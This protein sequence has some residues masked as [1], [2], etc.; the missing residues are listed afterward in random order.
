MP[1]WRRLAEDGAAP[2]LW[3]AGLVLIVLGNP[4][5]GLAL[6]A[7][8]VVARA[9]VRAARRRSELELLIE[10]VSVGDVMET[11]AFAVVP[12]AT[13]DS[14]AP[15]LEVGGPT[16]VARVMRDG[17][18]VGLVGERELDAVDRDRWPETHAE[19]AMSALDDLPMLDPAEP[20]RP[21]ADRLGASDVSGF[22]VMAEG[23]VAGILTRLAVGRT[24]HERSV[25]GSPA[26]ADEGRA[27]R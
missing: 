19:D 7:A 15:A 10:G 26:A 17:R 4:I 11:E 14:F 9:A 3:L 23:R 1:R 2:A 16:T 24:L 12:Y 20:L 21:A 18:L 22:P 8:G 13:L 5:G 6:V 27:A 25:A